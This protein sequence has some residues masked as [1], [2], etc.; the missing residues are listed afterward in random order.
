MFRNNSV[1]DSPRFRG[2]VTNFLPRKGFGFVLG[3]DGVQV[4]I[5][6]SDIRGKAFRTLTIGEE[7]EYSLVEGPKGLQAVDLVRLNPPLEEELPPLM[8]DNKTW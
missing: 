4:F 7:V 1:N 2:R 8:P 6:Y 5:H 3:D